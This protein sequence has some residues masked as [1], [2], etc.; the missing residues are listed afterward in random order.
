[1]SDEKS[2]DSEVTVVAEVALFAGIPGEVIE[3]KTFDPPINCGNLPDTGMW[4]M[5]S[6]L[7]DGEKLP[8]PLNDAIH[9]LCDGEYV[10][11]PV[12][13]LT[14]LLPWELQYLL[15]YKANSQE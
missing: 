10:V 11:V 12:D 14:R 15:N 2:D 1:M 3:R 5:L 8:E 4:E 13:Q 6:D 7:L 9:K